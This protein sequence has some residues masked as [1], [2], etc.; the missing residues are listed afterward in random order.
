[1][2][3]TITIESGTRVDSDTADDSRLNEAVSNDSSSTAQLIPSTGIL[4]GYLSAT[5]GIY[6]DSDGFIFEYV[7][8]GQDT[9][10]T[11]LAAGS[12]IALQVFK[13][14]GFAEPTITLSVEQGGASD[15][16]S[17]AGD[18]PL[19]VS[20]PA[21]GPAEISVRTAGGGPFRYV[22][23]VSTAGV[24][25]FQSS[26]YSQPEFVPDEAVVLMSAAKQSRLGPQGI[27][28]ALSASSAK[29]LGQ[30]A[31]LVRRDPV[32][33]VAALSTGSTSS[34]RGE[35]LRW[36]AELK[37]EPGVQVAEPN[38][39]YRAQADRDLSSLQWNLPLISLPLAWQ[40]APG[41]GNSIGVA[42][43]DTGLFTSTPQTYGNWHLDLDAN[44][45]PFNSGRI[46][47][48]VSADLDIDPQ[49][50]D[51]LGY[52]NNPADP[53]DGKPQSSNFHG[54]HVAGIVAALR[55]SAGVDGV[56]PEAT[57]WPV[58]VLGRDGAGTLDDLVAA[59][60]WAADNPDIDVIN[61][62]LGGVGPS[63]VLE[64]AVNRADDNGKL[65]VAAAGNQG[66]DELTYPAAFERVIGVGAVDGGKLRASYSNFGGSVDLVAPGGD[67]TRDANLDGNA[68]LIISTWGVDDGGDFIRSYAGLQGT[69]MAAPHVAGVY[70]LMKGA[71]PEVVTP[72]QF[73]AWLAG[74]VLTENVGNSTEYGAGLINALKSVDAALDGAVSTIVLSSPSAIEFDR[75]RFNRELD[76]TVYPEGESVVV[77]GIA[78]DSDLISIDPEL[79][80]G[81]PLPDSVA[82]AVVEEN[83]VDGQTYSTTIEIDYS[84][85]GDSGN[86]EIPVSI[87]LRALADERDAGRHYVLLVSPD[88]SRETIEQRV[89][90]ARDGSYSFS[91]DDI[92]PGEYFLVAGTDMDNNGFICESGEACAEYPVNGLPEKIVIGEGRVSGVSLST[93]FRRPTIA[94]MGLP[95]I[96][97]EGYRLKNHGNASAEPM[98]N[99][100][101]N[102]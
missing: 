14:A 40:A 89:V 19:M 94:S 45:I 56:A 33:L 46:L 36:I 78:F 92:E 18:T 49:F 53:G 83:V 67:A 42:V 2:S 82:V 98:R 76:F 74:G 62:S 73:R 69:S 47:D 21:E 95:R 51:P 84:A 41:Q 48:Y 5:S 34:L 71:N 16:D 12:T 9:F 77:N 35:T 58:R 22:L 96:G 6:P 61:L 57:L 81:S 38:Y 64:A 31:W 23:S 88:E 32:G 54:T 26:H 66:T 101:T 91:F 20:A 37:A 4:G 75:A 79:S 44:V 65:V 7:I 39:I 93:S 52:D 10:R 72:G 50:S 17:G 30:G 24:T 87:D 86:L 85:G 60:N 80:A 43:M 11:D 59:V 70:A 8:D 15:S 25:N 100:E 29:S 27:A 68:D 55:D 97:F 99:L 13:D 28:G 63:T 102:R 1:M 3:G 90:T